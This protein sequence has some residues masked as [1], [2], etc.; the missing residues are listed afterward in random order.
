MKLVLPMYN[1]H[2]YFSLKNLAKS[3]HY[4]QQNMVTML[5]IQ[6]TVCDMSY[7]EYCRSETELTLPERTLPLSGS[8]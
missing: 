8:C 7:R 6:V 2:L 5:M 1:A 4:T 3:A